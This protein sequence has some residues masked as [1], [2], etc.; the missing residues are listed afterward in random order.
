MHHT[1][2]PDSNG[3]ADRQIWALHQAPVDNVAVQLHLSAGAVGVVRKI[4]RHNTVCMCL[5]P[6]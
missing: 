6:H 2:T 4:L 1:F 3:E 5:V